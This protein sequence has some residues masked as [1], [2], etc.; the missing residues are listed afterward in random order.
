[1]MRRRLVGM[2]AEVSLLDRD[3]E[4]LWLRWVE[5]GRCHYGEQKWSA[6]VARHI[7]QCAL[8]GNVINVGDEV[9]RPTG[10]PSPSNASAQILANQVEK[11]IIELKAGEL[12]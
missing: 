3:R 5:P 2:D 4:H 12:L 10:R 1:M 9:F 7:G 6:S 8:T 11:L